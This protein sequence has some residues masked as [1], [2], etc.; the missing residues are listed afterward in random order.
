ML[1]LKQIRIKQHLSQKE[2]AHKAGVGQSTIHYI[3]SGVKS[4]TFKVI[5]KL[6]AALGVTVPEL[7]DNKDVNTKAV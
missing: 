7:I 3:E 5:E 6:A 4:P 2:L 1:L